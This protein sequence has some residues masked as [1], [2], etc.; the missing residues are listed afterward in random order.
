MSCY[1]KCSVSL[2]HGA[3]SWSAMNH[4]VFSWLKVLN[5]KNPELLKFIS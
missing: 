4:V 5:F 2:P 3:V 1:Y